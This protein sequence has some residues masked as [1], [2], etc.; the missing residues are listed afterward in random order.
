MLAGA[1]AGVVEHTAMYPVDTIKTRAQALAHPGQQLHRS[2]LKRALKAAF[3]HDGWPGLYR[4]IGAVVAGAGPAHAVYFLTYETAKKLYGGDRPGHQVF[5]TGLAGA[6]ATIVQDAVMT[7]ADVVKQRLQLVNTPYRSVYDC[8][9]RTFREEGVWAF[10][11]SYRTT[12]F[13][14]VPYMAVQVSTYES[15]KK[16]MGSEEEDGLMIQLTAGAIAGGMAA[17]VTNPLDVVKTRLQTQGVTSATTYNRS[18]VIPTMKQI[19]REEGPRA[20]WRG[21]KPRVMFHVPAA[22]ICWGTY[23]TMKAL[24]LERN[25][26][27]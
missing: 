1:V 15:C 23:E 16:L 21:L 27:Q 12:L 8:T 22:A 18:A 14:N 5:A 26:S 2:A 3:R 25:G 19:A 17:G 10:Y 7:P 9:T 11:R 13:M 4:G 6:T 24:L 20:L